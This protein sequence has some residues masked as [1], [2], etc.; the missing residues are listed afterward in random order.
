[1]LHGGWVWLLDSVAGPHRKFPRTFYGLDG[2]VFQFLSLFTWGIDRLLGARAGGFVLFLFVFPV[3][4]VGM[5][6]LVPGSHIAR[7]GASLFY[8]L[9]PVVFDR[10]WVGHSGYL[11]GYALLPFVVNSFRAARSGEQLAWVRVGAWIALATAASPHFIWISIFL[12]L[13][14]LC[15]ERPTRRVIAGAA[16]AVTLAGLCSAYLLPNSKDETRQ[17]T[18]D[19]RDISAYSAHAIG[20]EPLAFTVATMRGFWRMDRLLPVNDFPGRELLL[21]V[22]AL[23][24]VLGIG[25]GVKEG[26]RLAR[27][28]VLASVFA[29]LL[30]LGDRGPT[31]S[32]FMLLFDHVPGF[33]IMREPLKFVAINAVALSFAFG[34]GIDRF[35]RAGT[36]SA[37]KASTSTTALTAVIAIV[38]PLALSPGLFWGYGNRLQAVDYPTT[39]D[40]ADEQMTGSGAVLALPWHQYL[41]FPFLDERIVVNPSSAVFDRAVYEG[42]NVELPGLATTWSST[43]SEYL[44][45]LYENGTNYSTFGALTAPLDIHY[46]ALQKT[47]DWQKYSWLDNQRDLRKIVDNGDI[48]IYENLRWSDRS[49]GIRSAVTV[50]DWGELVNYSDTHGDVRGVFT[51]RNDPGAVRSPSTQAT[52]ELVP[53]TTERKNA[54]TYRVQTERPTDIAVLAERYLSGWQVNSTSATIFETP[55]GGMAVSTGTDSASVQFRPWRRYVF[56]YA[57]SLCAWVAVIGLTWRARQRSTQKSDES[58]RLPTSGEKD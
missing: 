16:L 58:D 34:L 8:C 55:Q 12:L 50:E 21:V 4:A 30:A 38:V 10:L 36:D 33:A 47:V 6:R 14:L 17:F 18:V 37:A 29:T 42:D 57:V 31:G 46:I 22:G 19:Q 48:T 51:K 41:T 9:T 32:L 28:L 40:R 44:S 5:W 2:G 56:A 53:A 35:Q 13:G 27:G 20:D 43:S 24:V 52:P 11:V 3:A 7:L 49:Y 1:M 26:R 54:T 39:W 23:I 25:W 15:T 45:Y